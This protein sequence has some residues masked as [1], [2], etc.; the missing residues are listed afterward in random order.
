MPL[1]LHASQDIRAPAAGVFSLLSTPERLPHWNTSVE[2]ARRLAPGEPIRLGSRAIMTGRLLGQPLESETE[3]VRF[4]PPHAFATRALRGPMLLTQ[5]TLS[6]Q[7][8]GCRVEVDVSGEVPGGRL[9]SMLAEGFLRTQL[10]ASL[11]R[12]RSLC[13]RESSQAAASEAAPQGG[14]PACWLHLTETHDD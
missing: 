1:H 13:E 8:Y 12:L 3:V 9:G 6:S 10:A 5:F 11:E 7:P 14:D 2:T 4:E